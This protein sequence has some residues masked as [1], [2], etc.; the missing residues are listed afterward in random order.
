[1]ALIVILPKVKKLVDESNINKVDSNGY[2]IY[3]Y[4]RFE[5]GQKDRICNNKIDRI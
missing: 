1:M 5:L 3:E 2:K 4:N